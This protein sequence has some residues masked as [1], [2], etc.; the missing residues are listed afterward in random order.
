MSVLVKTVLA[1]A[2]SF[3]VTKSASGFTPGE[4]RCAEPGTFQSILRQL[5]SKCARN[6]DNLFTITRLVLGWS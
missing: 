2:F 5:R 4:A 1:P 6:G 3:T